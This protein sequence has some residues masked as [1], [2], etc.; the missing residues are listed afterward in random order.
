MKNGWN[1]TIYGVIGLICLGA[2]AFA[3]APPDAEVL[4]EHLLSVT[5]KVRAGEERTYEENEFIRS[6]DPV[7]AFEVLQT[8]EQDASPDVRYYVFWTEENLL[9]SSQ[10]LSLELR[11]QIIERLVRA[12]CFDPDEVVSYSLRGSYDP[13]YWGVDDFTEQAKAWIREQLGSPNPRNSVMLLS[14]LAGLQDQMPRLKELRST[15]DDYLAI[16]DD[17]VAL[18]LLSVRGWQAR[19]ALARL[20]SPEDIAHCIEKIESSPDLYTRVRRLLRRYEYIR[21]PDVI[22]ILQRYLERDD[23]VDEGSTPAGYY[24]QKILEQIVE[25]FPVNVDLATARVWMRAQTEFKI[26]R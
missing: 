17:P 7:V 8:F 18:T 25:G 15:D 19:V 1:Q 20:G 6:A 14:G 4:R 12:I 21:Q 24:A 5:S 26:K 23:I 10:S 3:V 11:R 2:Q 13:G 16:A 9:Y 22:P